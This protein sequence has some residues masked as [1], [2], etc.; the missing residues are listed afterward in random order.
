MVS[1]QEVLRT[2]RS[3]AGNRKVTQ[4]TGLAELSEELDDGLEGLVESLQDEFG[5]ELLE[6][7]VLEAETVGDLCALIVQAALPA[8]PGRE[9]AD[10]YEERP[11]Y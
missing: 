11:G 10:F 1:K 3:L 7:S 2:I 5:V 9:A 8:P 4:D 6:E